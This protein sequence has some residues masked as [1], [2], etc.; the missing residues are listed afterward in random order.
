MLF[1]IDSKKINSIFDAVRADPKDYL[2]MLI[3][4]NT[5]VKEPKFICHTSTIPMATTFDPFHH[6]RRDFAIKHNDYVNGNKETVRRCC[7][8]RDSKEKNKF[9]PEFVSSSCPCRAFKNENNIPEYIC[10]LEYCQAVSSKFYHEENDRGFKQEDVAFCFNGRSI[11]DM[12]YT[13]KIAAHMGCAGWEDVYEFGDFFRVL[14]GL[15]W[16]RTMHKA[17]KK[18]I[19]ARLRKF[20]NRFGPTKLRATIQQVF[21]TINGIVVKMILGF[22]RDIGNYKLFERSFKELFKVLFFEYTESDETLSVS[23]A[24][25]KSSLYLELRDYFKLWK[26]SF[27]ASTYRLRVQPMYYKFRSRTLRELFKPCLSSLGDRIST[28]MT[29]RDKRLRDFTQG[30]VWYATG[31]LLSYTRTLGFLPIYLAT[32]RIFKYIEIMKKENPLKETEI[33]KIGLGLLMYLDKEYKSNG[34][35]PMGMLQG[36]FTKVEFM[37]SKQNLNYQKKIRDEICSRVNLDLKQSASYT[38]LVREG[39]KLED[40]R[41]I[42]QTAKKE[43][44]TIYVRDLNTG[45]VIEKYPVSKYSMDEKQYYKQTLYWLS[46][47]LALNSMVK[48]GQ[49]DKRFYV[50]YAQKD[51]S[52][53]EVDCDKVKVLTIRE[54]GK[55][56]V[57]IKSQ[58]VLVWALSIFNKLVQNGLA[59]LPDHEIGLKSTSHMWKHY[60]RLS[61]I[62]EESKFLYDFSTGVTKATIFQCFQDWTKATDN[63]NPA[64]AQELLITLCV[65]LKLPPWWSEVCILMATMPPEFEFVHET[66]DGVQRVITGTF[67]RGLMMGNPVTKTVLHL[68]HCP[69]KSIAYETIMK[70]LG[71]IKRD[72]SRENEISKVFKNLNLDIL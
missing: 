40:A 55:D 32:D 6:E 41:R 1:N 33:E 8:Y 61:P 72:I 12:V 38:S 7:L 35:L 66:M 45:R 4:E 29:V 48:K 30:Q 19:F 26:R 36:V 51:G 63:I 46:F 25:E 21:Y 3:K 59:L 56:R 5:L 24:K 67:K 28:Q 44:F 68:M 57:L 14:N 9:H 10:F 2:D 49:L 65:W 31:A 52:L 22:P 39:G 11:L 70:N 54:P 60:E 64:L 47:Q 50:R 13:N 17:K 43:N 58:S 27:H 18:S 42:L 16:F 34:K 15:Y 37:N 69:I 71:F 23:E 62:N 20:L 53:F